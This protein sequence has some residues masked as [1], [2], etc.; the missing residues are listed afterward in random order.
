MRSQCASVG[1]YIAAA[2]IAKATRK[3]CKSR[4]C[5]LRSGATRPCKPRPP[6]TASAI[7][8][9]DSVDSISGAP[10]MAP[11]PISSFTDALAVP[12]SS[13]SRG[14]MV[15]GRA[16]PTAANREPVTPSEIPSL[17]PRCSSALVK[18]SD[19]MRITSSI[20][21]INSNGPVI[22]P[23]SRIRGVERTMSL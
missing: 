15:S 6:T 16:V 7:K 4:T 20:A 2:V 23:P 14:T 17:S 19:A 12:L 1:T 21:A 10:R 9:V 8:A 5:P 22:Y 18:S 11:T 13:A 3:K